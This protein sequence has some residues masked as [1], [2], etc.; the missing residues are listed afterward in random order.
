MHEIYFGGLD[1]GTSGVRI[2]II[3]KKK[4]IIYSSSNSEGYYLTKPK[5]WLLICETLLSDIPYEIK[6]RLE[7]ISVSGTSGTLLACQMNGTAL[8]DAIP[9]NK[10][11]D[12]NKQQLKMIAGQNESLNNPF[13]GLA[14]ALRLIDL[15]G[16]DILLRHQ[17][18]WISGW[19]MNNWLFGEEG[20]NIKLGWSIK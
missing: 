19:L 12:G 3:N 13:S 5:S 1:F 16:Q 9:Y 10:I 7:R 18:D 6:Q 4:D 15:D 17:S 8:G 11:C 14:K 2:T 20:N